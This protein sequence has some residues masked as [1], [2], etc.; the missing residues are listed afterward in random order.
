MEMLSFAT[1]AALTLAS[2]LFVVRTANLVHA[3]LAL[4]ASLV[5]TAALFA[6][7]GASL[8]AGVQL[9]LYVGGVMTLALFGLM[10]T[11]RHES[12]AVP[13]ESQN[14]GRAAAASLALF[15][16]VAWAI[17]ETPGLD[18]PPR[19]FPGGTRAV[20]HALVSTDLLAFELLSVLLLAAIVGAIVLARRR[21]PSAPMQAGPP[22]RAAT[23][24]VE[25]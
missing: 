14:T 25:R 8:L 23:A 24:G 12:L 9:L 1:L 16:A 19:D 11:R 15:G 17:F 4:G 13:A 22:K 7:L 21:D 5:A 2:A 18:T 3:T 10:L 20:G 6:L